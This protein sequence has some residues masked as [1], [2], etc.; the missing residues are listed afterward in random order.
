MYPLTQHV[1]AVHNGE[2]RARL[3]PHT[4]EDLR[5]TSRRALLYQV[6]RLLDVPARGPSCL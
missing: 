1:H 3:W 2:V 6:R 4:P 5:A